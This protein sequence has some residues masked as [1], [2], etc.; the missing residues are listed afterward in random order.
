MFQ[1]VALPLVAV[2]FPF[3]RDVEVC[4]S[5][6]WQAHQPFHHVPD[7]EK[8]HTHLQDLRRVYA[9]VVEQPLCDAC[10]AAAEEHSTKVYGREPRYRQ[11]S[12]ANHNHEG[13]DSANREKHKINRDLF[14]IP[15]CRLS[16]P[17]AKSFSP[18]FPY[19]AAPP[20]PLCMHI[21]S[22]FKIVEAN[23]GIH[24]AM[25]IVTGCGGPLEPMP[26]G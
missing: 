8:H 3:E 7:V 5:T 26:C 18:S 15:R 13:K 4:I 14:L 6:S 16:S 24:E 2:C 21:P 17:K 25:N 11:V 1:V 19:A 23:D 9:L 22:P 10:L 20:Q 12:I